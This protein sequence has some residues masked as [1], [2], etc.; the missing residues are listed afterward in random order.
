VARSSRIT[1]FNQFF[2]LILL[3]ASTP[4]M[5][6]QDLSSRNYV[7]WAL[8]GTGEF[9]VDWIAPALQRAANCKLVA[10]VSRRIDRARSICAKLDVP[11]A[12]DSID[13]IDVKEVQ[14]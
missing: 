14:R 6:Y 8:V 3:L 1:G 13:A 2:A 11:I 9:A 5:Q 4:S 10:V 7:R 12:Y